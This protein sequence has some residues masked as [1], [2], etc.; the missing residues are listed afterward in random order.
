M[1]V[2][3]VVGAIVI[4]SSAFVSAEA[5]TASTAAAARPIAET[6]EPA[7][8]GFAV[9]NTSSE[10][11][12]FAE[13]FRDEADEA[14]SAAEAVSSVSSASS[15]SSAA[16]ATSA[17]SA[18]S[19]SSAASGASGGDSEAA[20]RTRATSSGSG[21]TSSVSGASFPSS[22]SSSFSRRRSSNAAMSLATTVDAASR[23]LGLFGFLHSP[24]RASF[25]SRPAP[26]SA[27]RPA[28]KAAKAAFSRRR[29]TSPPSPG[30]V[31]FRAG[32]ATA[33][34]TAT[35]APFAGGS[36]AVPRGSRRRRS[37]VSASS[38]SLGVLP[39][40]L[41][42]AA[43]TAALGSPRGSARWFA[44]E[45]RAQGLGLDSRGEDGRG[46]RLRHHLL[47]LVVAHDGHGAAESPA[48]R[49]EGGEGR[50]ARQRHAVSIGEGGSGV[51]ERRVGGVVAGGGSPRFR[52]RACLE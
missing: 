42:L 18:A 38:S 41:E 48:A 6:A 50:N 43:V 3:F 4:A 32:S 33:T 1:Y 37:G 5:S 52:W 19:A 44:A 47:A 13:S 10:S 27:S 15:A 20:R 39:S 36:R 2:S 17:A 23:A 28:A 34:A 25:A 7:G 40:L 45:G 49:G 22:P 8:E 9:A 12:S 31:F 29:A 26:R 24:S 21:A 30:D 46:H 16:S 35:A 11:E 14:A 51:G